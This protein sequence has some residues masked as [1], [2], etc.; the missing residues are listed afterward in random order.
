VSRR[1]FGLFGR[2]IPEKSALVT[3][4]LKYRIHILTMHEVDCIA[5]AAFKSGAFWCLNKGC[6]LNEII[7]AIRTAVI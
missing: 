4:S 1:L 7:K 3:D 5:E 2:T 6:S